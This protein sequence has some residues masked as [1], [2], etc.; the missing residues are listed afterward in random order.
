MSTRKPE[1]Q[2]N[3]WVETAALRQSPGH[4]FYEKL[5]ELFREFFRAA[6]S[7]SVSK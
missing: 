1:Q 3:L 5:N 7:R 4:P 6:V 2:E